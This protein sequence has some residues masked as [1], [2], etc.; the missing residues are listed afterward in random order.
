MSSS[1]ES[2]LLLGGAY[3]I[4]HAE[5]LKHISE[6]QSLLEDISRTLSIE[7]MKGLGARFHTIRGGAGFFR[8]VEIADTAR[9]LEELLLKR[10]EESGA[11]ER[12]VLARALF[13]DLQ[14]KV[15]DLP[16]PTKPTT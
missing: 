2:K 4:F 8:F 15:S 7:E 9:Q 11:P 10:A 14:N 5:I 1:S 6:S 16:P 13:S 12:V 3:R